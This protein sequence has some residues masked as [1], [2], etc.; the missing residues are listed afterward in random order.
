MLG[1]PGIAQSVAE[2]TIS[3]SSY[4]VTSVAT[5]FG[6]AGAGA[7][8]STVNGTLGELYFSMFKNSTGEYSIEQY[9]PGAASTSVIASG[10]GGMLMGL[11][12]N[13]NDNMLYA[14]KGYNASTA[15]D[16]F[17]KISGS[18][19]TT[20]SALPFRVNAEY[21]STTLDRCNN[22]YILST[23]TGTPWSINVVA[24]FNMSGTI[25]QTDTTASLYQGLDILY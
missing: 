15:A 21:F 9:H 10:T 25:A 18:T 16:E 23:L 17:V 5:V 7:V 2:V 24:Q 13:P 14:I 20:L 22:R 11:R 12:F 8:G 19:V 3:G 1:S 4:T 6:I